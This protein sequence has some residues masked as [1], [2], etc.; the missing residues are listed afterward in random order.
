M[1]LVFCCPTCGATLR[2]PPAATPSA[3]ACPQCGDA[4]RVPRAAH[5]V[6]AGED[7]S[8]VS[9]EAAV[10]ARAGARCLSASVWLF[11]LGAVGLLSS[12][13]L[14]LAVA[15]RAAEVPDWTTTLIL[16]GVE[17]EICVLATA[18]HAFNEDFRVVVARDGTSGL[19]DELAEAALR[20]I[21]REV[22]WVATCDA[23]AT[24]LEEGRDD[25]SNGK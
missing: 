19:D 25:S 5:P 23:I 16:A 8:A 10:R 3:V 18:Y 7:V 9:P 17:T 15:G 11:G 13:T 2:V 1:T 24:A 21:A 6:E 12:L 20:I 4:I 14:R 22:G